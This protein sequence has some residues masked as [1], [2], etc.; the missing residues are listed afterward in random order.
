MLRREAAVHGTIHDM[1]KGLKLF[2]VFVEQ[3][4]NDILSVI[5]PNI[6]DMLRI[7]IDLFSNIGDG[8]GNGLGMQVGAIP[9]L[10]TLQQ[11]TDQLPVLSQALGDMQQNKSDFQSW[12][13]ILTQ[14]LAETRNNLNTFYS[15]TCP[16]TDVALEC[17]VLQRDVIYLVPL[18]TYAHTS[19]T[20]QAKAATDAAI[21]AGIKDIVDN[22]VMGFESA[23]SGLEATLNANAQG[24]VRTALEQIEVTLNDSVASIRRSIDRALGFQDGIEYLEAKQRDIEGDATTILNV[25]AVVSFFANVAAILLTCAVPLGVCGRQE[26]VHKGSRFI[27][28]ALV[29]LL[30]MSFFLWA[31]VLT[32]FIPGSVFY[33]LFGRHFVYYDRSASALESILRTDDLKANFKDAQHSCS[34]NDSLYKALALK[35]SGLDLDEIIAVPPLSEFIDA[36]ISTTTFPTVSFFDAAAMQPLIQLQE[37][38][39]AIDFDAYE[40][41]SRVDVTEI[42]IET[43]K[44]DLSGLQ[45]SMDIEVQL[46][47]PNLTADLD[48][49]INISSEMSILQKLILDATI[50]ARGVDDICDVAEVVAQL[51]LA[52]QEL[53]TN[54]AAHLREVLGRKTRPMTEFINYI[55]GSVIV[56]VNQDVGHCAILY[57]V[58]L[59]L[60]VPMCWYVFNPIIVYATA[61][62]WYMI[63]FFYILYFGPGL[64]DYFAFKANK[65]TNKKPPVNGVPPPSGTAP[66]GQPAPRSPTHVQGPVTR[67]A[68][69]QQQPPPPPQQ[70]TEAPPRQTQPPQNLQRQSSTRLRHRPSQPVEPATTDRLPNDGTGSGQQ[71]SQDSWASQPQETTVTALGGE[72]TQVRGVKKNEKEGDGDD[73]SWISW[74]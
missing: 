74:V 43:Y 53:N 60:V 13:D 55:I 22:A 56:A 2:N 48:M 27:C 25:A 36:A 58:S 65:M 29:M 49:A 16:G 40:D 63:F 71:L 5:Y 34:H 11:F 26:H 59:L 37:L 52:E 57:R 54:L 12:N 47:L 30:V 45:L 69:Q 9:A 8:I 70:P 38:L 50:S 73:V 24:P 20:T 15:N 33:L 19:D 42:D 10:Y 21:L 14:H 3:L 68:S 7:I 39:D 46:A 17:A 44:L 67:Q 64:M 62:G 72:Q 32:A 51:E 41:A 66:P 4:W 31:A 18:A 28:V 6:P 35:E 23:F 61:M 1:L